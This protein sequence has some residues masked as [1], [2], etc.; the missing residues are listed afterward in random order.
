MAKG[1]TLTSKPK[2]TLSAYEPSL[3]D[4]LAWMLSDLVGGDRGTTN[5]INDKV[6]GAAD[7]IPGVGDA[8]GFDEAKRDFDA[9]NY[10]Q[11]AFGAATSAVGS[12]PGAGDLAAAGIKGAGSA[13]G[14]LMGPSSRL[15][16]KDMAS[17]ALDMTIDRQPPSRVWSETKTELTPFHGAVQEIPDFRA[18]VHPS[19]AAWE[20]DGKFTNRLAEVGFSDDIM[21]PDALHDVLT[22]PA[23]FEAYPE[24][25]G[26][27]VTEL[28]AFNIPG[29]GGAFIPGEVLTEQGFF[30]DE[31]GNAMY[32]EGLPDEFIGIATPRSVGKD[33]RE[34]FSPKSVMLH[35]LQH[36]VQSRE[37]WDPGFN[38]NAAKWQL[39]NRPE[40]FPAQVFNNQI[41][42]FPVQP[43]SQEELNIILDGLS[44]RAAHETYMRNVG[45]TQ[46][47]AVQARAFPDD[48][49]P[50]YLYPP[51]D[52][53]DRR[54]EEQ[55]SADDILRGVYDRPG[56]P[57]LSLRGPAKRLR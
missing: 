51:S 6:R 38:P 20:R 49:D 21:Y 54:W 36:W 42:E 1:I 19:R 40:S 46:A 8:V 30:D 7:F 45:E 14:I 3:R 26:V 56:V 57:G 25:K 31:F 5:Y 24:A 43:S 29:P 50:S 39:L 10:G 34:N 37:G 11:A 16:N 33:A 27:G 4:N 47:R 35:E 13:L 17:K 41:A 55:L 44:G 2:G 23:F 52:Y 12:I 48:I 32:P 53:M 9:G 15:W 28:E 22:H 18:R